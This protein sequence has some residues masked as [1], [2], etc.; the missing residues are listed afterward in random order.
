MSG[1]VSFHRGFSAEDAVDRHYTR[2]G[3]PIA[4][5]RWRGQCGEIDLVAREGDGLVFIEVKAARTHDAAALRLGARQ[6]ARIMGA[7]A[8]FLAGEPRG[9]STPA[10]FDLAL[11]DGQGRVA[12]IE[13]AFA[14]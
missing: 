3:R 6:V 2:S 7:A 12:V 4:R 5:R 14:A 13:N 8:E 9:L 10:R 11:V 1:I